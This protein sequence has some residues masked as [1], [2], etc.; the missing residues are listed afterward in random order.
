MMIITDLRWIRRCLLPRD[1]DPRDQLL[2]SCISRCSETRSAYIRNSCVKIAILSNN[3]NQ[4]KTKEERMSR[5]GKETIKGAF[6]ILPKKPFTLLPQKVKDPRRIALFSFLKDFDLKGIDK[7][8]MF[9]DPFSVP[10][11]S[12]QSIR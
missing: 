6:Q 9:F 10:T 1:S 8:E 5:R 4:F 11:S 3:N 7:M 2:E 12:I